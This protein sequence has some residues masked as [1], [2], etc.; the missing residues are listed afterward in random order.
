MRKKGGSSNNQTNKFNI[1][2][3]KY[4]V[5]LDDNYNLMPESISRELLEFMEI[6]L[7]AG[8]NET[9]LTDYESIILSYFL[10]DGALRYILDDD[11]LKGPN[12]MVT[13][14]T[15]PPI[16][17]VGG[18]KK[19]RTKKRKS[20]KRKY[21]KK[22]RVQKGSG[23]LFGRKKAPKAVLEY[24]KGDY[25]IDE[26]RGTRQG[27][28]ILKLKLF[29]S[30]PQGAQDLLNKQRK[31]NQ[32]ERK[33]YYP[34]KFN[35]MSPLP[36]LP[37][38]PPVPNVDYK[39]YTV[40]E[41]LLDDGKIYNFMIIDNYK[42]HYILSLKLISQEEEMKGK[43]KFEPYVNYD[44]SLHGAFMINSIKDDLIEKFVDYGEIRGYEI[45]KKFKNIDMTDRQNYSYTI[46]KNF[47]D[48]YISLEDVINYYEYEKVHKIP[49]FTRRIEKLYEKIYKIHR[50]KNMTINDLSLRDVYISK[51]EI[52]NK[53]SE[54]IKIITRG[55]NIQRLASA[56]P[57]IN[58]INDLFNVIN[59]TGSDTSC[60]ISY[61]N[62]LESI[63]LINI[64]SSVGNGAIL[65]MFNTLKSKIQDNT[66]CISLNTNT[67]IE[68]LESE[69]QNYQG[70][71]AYP[72]QPDYEEKYAEYK[73]Y[74]YLTHLNNMRKR[75]YDV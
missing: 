47:T 18:S 32:I 39:N 35:P 9:P 73:R 30:T 34:L 52:T 58:K 68:N 2:S 40:T 66:I 3:I 8:E 51:N 49:F 62:L 75:E 48:K 63:K 6:K 61:K 11:S 50:I 12:T 31:T 64:D 69:L 24:L 67:I 7:D 38:P 17:A 14:T 41:T 60:E 55:R 42:T 36:P 20:K 65:L 4:I 16:I 27:A 54:D 37:T 74:L 10:D 59:Y 45:P 44:K 21:S 57:K 29:G 13:P 23:P 53:K 22:K 15:E 28:E 43:K 26:T 46:R 33:V 25:N 70:L 56:Q 1:D 72:E 71:N 19:K 5:P